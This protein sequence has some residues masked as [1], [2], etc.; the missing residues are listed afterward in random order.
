[1]PPVGA[2]GVEPTLSGPGSQRGATLSGAVTIVPDERTN[3]LLVHASQPDFEVLRAAVDQLDIRPLQ[4]L[5]EVLIVEAERDRSLS[6]GSN[7]VLP[8]QPL[9]H[10]HGTIGGTIAGASLGDFVLNLLNVGHAQVTA[11]ISA[12]ASR[13]DVKIISRPVLLASNNTEA[14]ILV[15][16]QQP[17]V[18]VSLALPTSTPAMD[19]VVQYRDVGTKLTVRPT[20]D[21]D[22]YVSL[23]IHQEVSQATAVTQ[24]NA[25]VIST[26]EIA[27]QVLVRDSQTIVL[28]GMRDAE[29]DVTQGG[30]PFLSS[31]P[32]LGGL[33][34]SANRT[35]NQT[36]FYLFLTPRI[37]KN[38][39]DAD[40]VTAPRLPA[41][42]NE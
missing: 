42:S 17:F 38:D 39:A 30:V 33:F 27:T 1:V 28:G 8:P 4:V 26:R 22:G 19:Q 3:S 10:T 2:P 16:S 24:F 25:P 37:L 23:D 35:A 7:I 6:L 11:A 41:R 12:A 31:I 29:L 14:S 21:Q 36:E 15:G 34:G 5:I 32:L 18:Q 13:G 9:D 40:G 20:I